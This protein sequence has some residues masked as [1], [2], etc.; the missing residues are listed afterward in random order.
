MIPL[1]R[2]SLGLP[3][4]GL[5]INPKILYTKISDKMAH[6]NSTDPDLKEQSD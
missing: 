5:T 2:P 4:S 3:K 6:A 1:L